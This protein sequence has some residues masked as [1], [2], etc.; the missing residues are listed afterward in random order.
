M[1]KVKSGEFVGVDEKFIK[2]EDKYVDP[3]VVISEEKQKKMSN[4]FLKGI[5][6]YPLIFMVVSSIIG[7][8]TFIVPIVIIPL[9]VS[10]FM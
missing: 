1:R 9:I 3:S 2:E 10:Q 6:I 4:N 5:L 7:I 8:V